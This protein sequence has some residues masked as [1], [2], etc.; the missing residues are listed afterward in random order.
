MSEFKILG[1]RMLL[2][3]PEIESHKGKLMSCL[4]YIYFLN[5]DKLN[6]IFL[7]H[8]FPF[9]IILYNIIIILKF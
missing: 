7:K 5:S 9:T 2:I 6:G 4:M 1:I 3:P 8:E